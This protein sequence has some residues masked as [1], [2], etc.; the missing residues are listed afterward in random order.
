MNAGFSFYFLSLRVSVL[1]FNLFNYCS[2]GVIKL[3]GSAFEF[4]KQVFF[5]YYPC[6]SMALYS[7]DLILVFFLSLCGVQLRFCCSCFF[8]MLKRIRG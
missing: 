7:C 3:G 4:T 1:V 5:N 6:A 2:F 8:Y